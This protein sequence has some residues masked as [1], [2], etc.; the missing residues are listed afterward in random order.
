MK[1]TIILSSILIFLLLSSFFIKIPYNIDCSGKILPSREWII[2]NIDGGDIVGI[3]NQNKSNPIY[4][5][6]QYKFERGDIARVYYS[7]AFTSNSSVKK[8]D[9]IGYI[10][11]Y[12]LDEKFTE[13]QGELNEQ[14]AYLKTVNTGEKGSMIESARNELELANEEYD[15]QLKNY[16]RQ[17]ALFE[18]QLISAIEYETSQKLYQSAKT[19]VVLARNNM[20]SVQTGGKQELI[21]YS[22]SKIGSVVN[23]LNSLDKKRQKYFLVAPFDGRIVTKQVPLNNP[24]VVT[25]HLLHVVDT[26]EYIVM[27]PIE[28]YQRAY[29]SKNVKITTIL[30]ETGKK[31]EGVY[32]GENQDVELTGNYK[33]VFIV[34]G[35]IK[36]QGKPVP[37]GI[38]ASCTIDCGTVSLFEYI[39]RKIRV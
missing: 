33:Q 6:V 30:P 28:L 9:T 23:E 31:I 26:S 20:L 18:K 17:K 21:E 14:Q 29:I 32:I 37:Y 39:K 27:L 7:K 2:R 4:D 3:Y 35:S 16:E 11:S 10:G 38:Y 15:L 36:P 8:G 19:K 5:Y 25:Y 12:L 13:L 34:K 24:E 1:Q 22:N